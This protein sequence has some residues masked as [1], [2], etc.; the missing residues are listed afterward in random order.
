MSGVG[1]YI[2]FA[3]RVPAAAASELPSRSQCISRSLTGSAV[4]GAC[5]V[6][7][8]F[9]VVAETS[10]ADVLRGFVGSRR[11]SA[12]T[13]ILHDLGIAGDDAW[14]LLEKLNRRFGTDF[15]RMSFTS[16]FPNETEALGVHWA[17]LLGFR[18][19]FRPITVGHLEKVIDRGVWFDP[20][21]N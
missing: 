3:V 12:D 18:S 2:L 16:Y 19:S 10:L 6:W 7:H 8:T 4:A 1:A 11:V 15:S 17:K 20:A 5:A 13:R 21:D 14:E 9:A